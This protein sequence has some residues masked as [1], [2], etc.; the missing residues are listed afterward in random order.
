MGALMKATVREVE[1]LV[2]GD[3]QWWPSF[4]MKVA[5]RGIDAFY[6][7]KALHG[8]AW[9]AL[10]G[11]ANADEGRERQWKRALEA[12]G[13]LKALETVK[14]AEM[15][16]V[17]NVSVSKLRVDTNFR[18]AGKVD[19]L[20]WGDKVEVNAGTAVMDAALV[21]LAVGLLERVK[22][23]GAMPTE[24]LVIEAVEEVEEI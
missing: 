8:W 14:I 12:Y 9:G 13:N 16:S 7:E 4:C 18:F 17:E 6:E 3:P 10:W 22:Q 11:W 24:K 20:R 1:E 19:R 5:E 15:S 2:E 23:V 21:G